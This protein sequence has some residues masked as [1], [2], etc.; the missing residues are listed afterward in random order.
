MT[1]CSCCIL[2]AD[3]LPVLVELAFGFGLE[4]V[5]P[6][7]ARVGAVLLYGCILKGAGRRK[8]MNDISF[9][10]RRPMSDMSF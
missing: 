1:V 7:P 9:L 8:S 2:F 3:A 10:R 5:V 4:D 6:F